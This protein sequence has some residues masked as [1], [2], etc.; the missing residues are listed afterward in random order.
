M[1]LNDIFVLYL[2]TLTWTEVTLC[3]PK[4]I[5]RYNFC[6]FIFQT[7]LYVIGGLTIG[8]QSCHDYEVIE[9]D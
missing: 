2:D 3:S 4:M 7:K 5:P 1:V 8:M 9:L 6:S